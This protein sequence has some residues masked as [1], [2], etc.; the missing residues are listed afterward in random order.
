MTSS[1]GSTF[2]ASIFFL[3]NSNRCFYDIFDCPTENTQLC[4]RLVGEGQ[5]FLIQL[6]GCS[7]NIDRMVGNPLEISDAVKHDGE[8]VT[9]PAA[10]ILLV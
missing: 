7:Q 1:R 8:I 10:Q 5:F 4:Q 2:P 6:P 9:V 3:K